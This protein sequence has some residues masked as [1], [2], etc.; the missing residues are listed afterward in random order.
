MYSY[1]NCNTNNEAVANITVLQSHTNV[2]CI[3]LCVHS[4]L[5]LN[6]CDDNEYEWDNSKFFHDDTGKTYDADRY[7][8]NCSLGE[9]I[10][11]LVHGILLNQ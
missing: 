9:Y 11:R 6:V 1:D 5:S 2:A 8:Y 4:I 3:K 7:F 10:S